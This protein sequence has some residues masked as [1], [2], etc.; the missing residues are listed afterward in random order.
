MEDTP[1]GARTHGEQTGV[2]SIS[3]P[4][5]LTLKLLISSAR[6]LVNPV[7]QCTVLTIDTAK[8]GQGKSWNNASAA[9]KEKVRTCGRLLFGQDSHRTVLCEL[10]QTTEAA[11]TLLAHFQRLLMSRWRCAREW[12]HQ[13]RNATKRCWFN[14]VARGLSQQVSWFSLYIF[15]PSKNLRRFCCFFESSKSENVILWGLPVQG[16]H[17]LLLSVRRFEGGNVNLPSF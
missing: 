4:L 13:V 11:R 5:P 8:G 1:S 2:R 14:T 12:L 3:V 10:G 17:L 15:L 16:L 6:E 7:K 9:L